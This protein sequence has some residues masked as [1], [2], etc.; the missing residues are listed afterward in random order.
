MKINILKKIF[1]AC[2]LVIFIGSCSQP[3]NQAIIFGL[4]TAPVTLDPR[5]T[6]DAVSYR[7]SRLI[8]QSLVDFNEQFEFEPSLAT[9]QTLSPRHYRFNLKANQAFDNGLKLNSNDV[10]ATYESV[11]KEGSVSPHK[12]SLHMIEKINVIDEQ[13]ID[14][15]LNADDALFPA[16]LVIGILPSA[17][18]EQ[19]HPFNTQPVGSGAVE[20]ID[21]QS[22]GKLMLQR[23]HDQQLLEFIEVKDPTVRVLKLLRGEVDLVQGNLPP[24]MVNWIAKQEQLVLEKRKGNLF[25]YIGF[26]MENQLTKQLQIRQAIAYAID[27]KTIIEYVMG[28]AAR[29]AGAIFPPSHWVGHPDLNGYEYNPEKS[30]Q[31]LVELGYNQDK[32][33]ELSYK[34]SNNPFRLRLATVI[35]DQ[36]KQVNIHLDIRSY[37]W[38]TFYGDIKSGNFQMYSL[39]WVGL[40]IPDIFRYVFH[41]ESIPPNG[42]NRGR[43]HSAEVD[44]FIEQAEVN[45]SLDEQAKLYQAVQEKVHEELPYIPMWYE[46]NIL[47][48]RKNISGYDLKA[49][50]NYDGLLTAKKHN[51]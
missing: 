32:P 47:A 2:L 4:N 50:G 18:I 45:H 48:Y 8:Y 39:S 44:A 12:S 3:N 5:F 40:K 25:T 9:W 30:K 49:D 16:R 43:Y 22:G 34:T 26:N 51:E 28:D 24:E 38:G 35:Q 21:W 10:K 14:F 46:D 13:T 27:R 23:K 41:S 1:L 33:L 36:L 19:D 31:L 20:L 11:I 15:I 29:L 6:T 42:A 37:D 17:L 7:I